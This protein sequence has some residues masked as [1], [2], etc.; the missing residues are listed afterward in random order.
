MTRLLSAVLLIILLTAAGCEQSP[1]EPAGAS[2]APVSAGSARPARPSETPDTA[3][4]DAGAHNPGTA[5]PGADNPEAGAPLG[6][7]PG[8][9]PPADAPSAPP[10]G[11]AQPSEPTGPDGA[12]FGGQANSGTGPGGGQR[13]ADAGRPAGGDEEDEVKAGDDEERHDLAGPVPPPAVTGSP[14]ISFDST[15]YDFGPVDETH[16]HAGSFQF[17][18]TGDAALVIEAIKPTCGCTAVDLPQREYAPGERGV[19]QFDFDPTAPG[20]QRKYIDVLSNDPARPLVRLTIAAEVQAFIVVRPR[21]LD[22]GVIPYREEHRATV[23]VSC[24]DGDFSFRNVRATNKYVTARALSSEES[25]SRLGPDDPPGARIIEVIVSPDAP[26]G[27][28]FS[29]LEMTVSGRAPG[30]FA[31]TV[32]TTRIRVNGQIFGALAAEPDTFR[33]GVP[34]DGSFERRIRL[35]HQRGEPFN[36]LAA[37]VDVPGLPGAQVRVEKAGDAAYELILT[38]TAGG[39]VARCRGAV[40]VNTDVEGEETIAINVVGVVRRPKEE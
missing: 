27:G 35:V 30:R 12:A 22:L 5:P 32:H 39:E 40:T 14:T 28:L 18:N 6:S 3:A 31:P 25:A 17:T 38:A 16:N 37:T 29:W 8:A 21:T 13:D 33:F 36:I 23:T 24:G 4:P 2:A 7:T 9:N 15:I 10:A 26:W 1:A 20:Q 19:L 34:T 11:S